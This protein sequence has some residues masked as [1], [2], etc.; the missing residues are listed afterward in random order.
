MSIKLIFTG[1]VNLMNVDDPEVPFRRV[2]ETLEA[3][4]VVFSNLECCLYEPDAGHSVDNEGF[5]VSAD[6]GGRALI[7]G[8]VRAVGLAN[9]VN[10]GAD[11]IASSIAALDAIGIA[12]TGAGA[13]LAAA[14]APALITHA[15]TRIG[16]LQRTSVYWPTH[17]EARATAPGVAVIRGHTAYQVPMHKLRP[18]I[19]PLNRP[20]L[21]PV[22]LTWA[23]PA[24]LEAFA[25]DLAGLRTHADVV[26][27]SLH[28]GLWGEVLQYMVE[29]AHRAIDAGADIV[30]GHGPHCTLPVEIY[31]GKPILYGL[32][33]FTFHTGHGGR[34]HGDWLGMMATMAV[35]SHGLAPDV[36][37][38]LVRHNDANE[39]VLRVPEQEADAVRDLTVRSAALGTRL[40]ARGDC[41]QITSLS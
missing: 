29:I 3:A 38:R 9:N 13:N 20:G 14:R 16:V 32:G 35:Q 10:Y 26:V 5:Y 24:Y 40:T 36:S 34:T 2:R 33:S 4:D 41:L 39:T 8:G 6:T 11:A 28:W 23:D 27:A 25:A 30:I 15:G 17:H 7:T 31:R 22:I 12:H 19:P 18:E 21:P 1:D 37:L